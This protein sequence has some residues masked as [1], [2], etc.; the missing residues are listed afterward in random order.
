[1]A[2]TLAKRKGN[3]GGDF[4]KFLTESEAVTWCAS[5]QIALNDRGRPDTQQYQGKIEKFNIPSDAG[6]RVALVVG[7]FENFK[8]ENE[9]LIWIKDWSIWKSGERMHIFDRF[10][11]SYGEQRSL[12]DAPAGIIHVNEYEDGL[13][14]VV[15]AVLFLWDCYILNKKGSKI[16]F[17]SHD[18][19][20]FYLNK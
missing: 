18:E 20:G 8:N 3:L 4:I 19:F 6:A 10:R 17:Y 11:L 5:N 9:T 2:K 12:C 14:I 7:K 16:L 15:C 13:S 1:M